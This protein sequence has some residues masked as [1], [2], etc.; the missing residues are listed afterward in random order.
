MHTI[1]KA[2]RKDKA[3]VIEILCNS[4]EHDP[5]INWLVGEESGKPKRMKRL[6]AYA[7]EH[8]FINGTIELTDD[9]KAV[10]LWKNHRS[11][12]MNLPLGIE[13]IR[14]LSAFGFERLKRI[15]Q[16]ENEIS[17]RY[18]KNRF[19]EYLWFI[20]TQPSEQGK[21]YGS[22]LL[23]PRLKKSSEENR[24]IYLETTTD[25]NVAYYQKKGFELYDKIVPESSA[26]LTIFL[27]KTA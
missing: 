21:G 10:A 17:K 8:A 23:R 15:T 14:F 19:F 7:F 9:V 26:S 13:N 27:L 12:K 1:I 25:S 18:P 22:A 6:M 20:G 24:S 4:F 3:R 11:D 5:H 2:Q 16:M